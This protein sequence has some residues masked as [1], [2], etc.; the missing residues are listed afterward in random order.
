MAAILSAAPQSDSLKPLRKPGEIFNTAS[1]S[2]RKKDG[3]STVAAFA[4]DVETNTRR[5]VVFQVAL[6]RDTRKGSYQLTDNRDIY[7]LV[8]IKAHVDFAH[9]S[10]L[11]FQAM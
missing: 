10:C 9:A 2:C 7:E 8:R 4:W 3:V 6:K 5:E 1:A 11:L